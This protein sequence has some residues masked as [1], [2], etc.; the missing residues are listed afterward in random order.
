MW[1]LLRYAE[2]GKENPDDDSNVGIV[3]LILSALLF[4]PDEDVDWCAGE[5]PLLP[6]LV[7]EESFVRILHVLGKVR[8]ENE[9]WYLCVRQ[10]RH[11]LDLDIFALRRWWRIVLDERQEEL[12]QLA[13]RYLSLLVAVYLHGGLYHFENALFGKC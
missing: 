9:G 4:L 5:F 11:I 3:S 7:F 8:V 13:G 6:H 12:V 1:W 2:E 10:L